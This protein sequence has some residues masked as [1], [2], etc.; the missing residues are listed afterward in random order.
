MENNDSP[1]LYEKPL[2]SERLGQAAKRT[3]RLAKLSALGLVGMVGI[4]GGTA[5]A[6]NVASSSRTESTIQSSASTGASASHAPM[7]S[8]PFQEATP[9]SNSVKVHLPAL[10]QKSFESENEYEY[11]ND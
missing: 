4:F 3:K 9:K 1:Y 2:R 7:V 5:I 8:V 10:P 6:G 11:E